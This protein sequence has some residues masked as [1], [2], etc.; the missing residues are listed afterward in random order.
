MEEY[1]FRTSIGYV[2]LCLDVKSFKAIDGGQWSAV[3]TSSFF[4]DK[5]KELLDELF[6]SAEIAYIEKM[7]DGSIWVFIKLLEENLV[8][9]EYM[10]E[11]I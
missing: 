8:A 6:I 4:V 1:R 3:R 5:G 11:K 7:N 2:Y 9:P 10:L